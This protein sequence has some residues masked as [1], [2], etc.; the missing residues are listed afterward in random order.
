MTKIL[1]VLV[2]NGFITYSSFAAVP[3]NPSVKKSTMA[4]TDILKLQLEERTVAL[5]SKGPAVYR[6]LH[7]LAFD[8]NQPYELR[9]RA[10]ISMAWLGNKESIVDLERAIESNDWFMRDAALKGLEKVNREK[11]IAWAKKLMSDPALVVRTAAVRVL[12]D[13][14]DTTS[15]TL[16]WEKLQASENFRGEQSLWIRRQIVV[17]LSDLAQRGTE[18][19]FAKLLEDKDKSLHVPAMRG[20]ERLTG[21]FM[22]QDPKK[23]LALWKKHFAQLSLAAE[24][25]PTQL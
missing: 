3:K 10:V 5:R 13:L 17:A 9:W 14:H 15:E 2:M 7:Q 4:V 23:A 16:L 22:D 21:K 8:T 6:E 11:A 24:T 1:A 25:M 20:L 19:Q 12:H 18:G